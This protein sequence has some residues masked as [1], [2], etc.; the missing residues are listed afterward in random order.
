MIRRLEAIVRMAGQ[1]MLEG[2]DARVHH[3][4][5]HFNFVTDMDL[6]IQE[7]LRRELTQLISGSAFFAEEQEN[8]SL[9][10]GPT[11]VVD[12]IDG[13]VNFMRGLGCSAVSVALLEG[14]TPMAGLIYNPFSNELYVAQKGLG[15]RL[16]GQP[17]RVSEHGF[18][19]A[20]VSF[21][22]SPYE[23]A[24]ARKGLSAAL[25]MLLQ[26]GDLR[27][28]GSAAM[29]LA[30]VACGRTDCFFEMVLSPWDYAAGALLVTEAGGIFSQ[31]LSAAL[32]FGR[33]ACI[34]ASNPACHE[35]ALAIVREADRETP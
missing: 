28:S 26:A 15:S 31:P 17:I 13:T 29:D 22:S 8:R 19:R 24:L 2:Q 30:S 10:N 21:G 33:P 1:M 18:E 7:M 32:D 5:G 35:P 9:G 16:N 6:R 34:L 20:L 27:R 12:P 3:K 11:W 14:R 25:Q 4:E 23:P